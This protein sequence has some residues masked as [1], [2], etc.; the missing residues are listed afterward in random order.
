MSQIAASLFY[1]HEINKV[2]IRIAIKIE[3]KH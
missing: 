2:P 1:F 3:L